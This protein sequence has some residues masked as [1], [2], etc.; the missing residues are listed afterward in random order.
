[1]AHCASSGWTAWVVRSQF[2][3]PALQTAPEPKLEHCELTVQATPDGFPKLRGGWRVPVS[4]N[5]LSWQVPQACR[6]GRVCQ[7]SST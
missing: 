2:P 6:E 5:R 4:K 7:R 1:V 3:V